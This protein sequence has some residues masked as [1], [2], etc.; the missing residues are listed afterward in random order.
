MRTSQRGVDLIK[1]FEGFR[2]NR[3]L[4]SVGVPTI[5]YGTTAAVVKPLPATCTREQ[6]ESWL[7]TGLAK[8]YEPA[9]NAIINAGVPLNSNQFDALVSFAYNLGP[10]ALGTGSTMGQRLRA[11]DY[12]GASAAF[13][14]YV[15]AG[16]RPLQ[17]LINRRAA[18]RKLFDTPVKDQPAPAPAKPE[19]PL[20]EDDDGEATG[21]SWLIPQSAPGPF[22]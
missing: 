3:Y 16:G 14:L 1:Q 20:L 17:G 22:P 15:N 9:V 4:D 18:E 5:G 13:M 2:A 10:G 12:R 11:H 6:A 8:S 21:T 19:P 7:R